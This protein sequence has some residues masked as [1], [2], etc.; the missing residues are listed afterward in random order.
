MVAQSGLTRASRPGYRPPSHMARRAPTRFPGP[1]IGVLH[2][3]ELL[4]Q[5]GFAGIGPLLAAVERDAA[6]LLAGGIEALLLENWR[7]ESPGPCV[8]PESVACLAL[9]ARAVRALS[10][11]PVG[12]NVLPNDYRAAFALARACEL[13]FVQ[14]DV[15]SDAVRT[16]YSYSQAPPFEVRVDLTDVARARRE[17]SAEGV[18]LLATVHPKHYALLEPALTLEE[19][20]RRALEHGADGLV[21]T[22]T[23]T[24]SA[25]DPARVARVKAVAGSAPVLVGSGLDLGNCAALL[26]RCEGA[27]VGT[28]LRGPDMGPVDPARVAAL[29]AA[30]RAAAG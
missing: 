10:P 29:V 1:L 17:L 4:G 2:L 7:D 11:G 5:P 6:A 30:V 23:H 14:L 26:A 27:I 9:V 20:A 15:F 28:A 8:G 21:V 22:G 19:S 12:I 18:L 13:A 24:G 3:G 16:D 25:P